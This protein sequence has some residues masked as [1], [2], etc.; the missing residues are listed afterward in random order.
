MSNTGQ[1]DAAIAPRHT[2]G[3]LAWLGLAVALMVLIL[4]RLHAYTLPLETD[5]CNYAYFGARLLA[6][7]RLYAD[8]WDH[9]PPGVFVL[10]AG[11]IALFGD[12]PVVFRHVAMV[13]SAL[14]LVL[15]FEL[16]RRWYG[17][18]IAMAGGL[19]FALASSDP[20]TAGEG[21]NREIYMNT[22]VLAAWLAALSGARATRRGVF[23]AGLMLGI[24]S[25][26]KTILAIHWVVLAGLLVFCWF[27]GAAAGGG[28]S[29]RDARLSRGGIGWLGLL[30]W[31][32]LGPLLVWLFVAGYFGMSGRWEAFIDAV[33]LFNLSYAE[34]TAGLIGRFTTFFVPPGHPF[35]F[36]SAIGLWLGAIVAPIVLVI[37]LSNRSSRGDAEVREGRAGAPETPGWRGRE[38]AARGHGAIL[39]MAGA[40]FLAVCLPAHYWPHYYYLLIP[41][42]I[43][44]CAA[45]LAS[46]PRWCADALRG[47]RVSV[48]TFSVLLALVAYTE[49]RDY[50]GQPP[51][52]ITIRRYETR[53]FWG[54]AQGE[55]VRRVTDP[56]DRV[57]VCGS[58]ASIYY[59]SRRRCASRFTMI[60]GVISNDPHVSRRRETLR[61]ELE[62]DP[63][64]IILISE[65]HIPF[66]GWAEFLAEHYGPPVGEDLH[67]RK[68]VPIM[69]VYARKD[70][71]IEPIDWDWDRSELSNL[72]DAA[73]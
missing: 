69:F 12:E 49:Y 27:R 61:A 8:L 58:D 68:R 10:F 70:K 35:T 20:G 63:P 2:H 50:L 52:G 22:F 33:F 39:G 71:P 16:L 23:G 15:M 28:G 60:S 62:R 24:G 45:A 3:P 65:P 14:S 44:L 25:T 30:A 73:P 38:P 59:Y 4:F 26:I 7:D 5:E 53:D 57:F 1:H 41:P 29:A 40:S 32:S 21:C 36:D 64:R 47:A 9:Q 6:G 43:L 42:T 54:R 31:F 34:G 72:G 66:D 17:P 18:L 51:L 67:D 55:N 13:F 56:A 46:L 11:V 37:D 48:F 19:L